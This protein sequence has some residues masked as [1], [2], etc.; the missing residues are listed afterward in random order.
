MTIF[1]KEKITLENF[2]FHVLELAT[3]WQ[4]SF[5]QDVC[6][7]KNKDKLH[8][9]VA[10]LMGYK[11]GY[12]QFLKSFT[13]EFNLPDT[14]SLIIFPWHV[15]AKLLVSSEPDPERA[16]SIH[17]EYGKDIMH[18]IAHEYEE[19]LSDDYDYIYQIP[20]WQYIQDQYIVEKSTMIT[21]MVST[22]GIPEFANIDGAKKLA[23]ELGL[24]VVDNMNSHRIDKGDLG[25]SHTV[26]T[27]KRK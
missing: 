25:T 5:N 22:H 1:D 6:F 14:L 27:M 2:D 23:K 18:I 24:S 15:E 3:L 9:I 20:V 7:E 21:R 26:F 12:S 11:D 17:D 10:K 4:D 16:E 13:D 8:D 19:A